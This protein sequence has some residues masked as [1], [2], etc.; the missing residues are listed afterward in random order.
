[1]ISL[2]VKYK[3]PHKIWKILYDTQNTLVVIESRDD[4]IYEPLFAAIE[5]NKNKILWENKIIKQNTLLNSLEIRHGYLFSSTFQ[6][7]QISFPKGI[8]AY[9]IFKEKIIWE[10]P[11]II[12]EKSHSKGIIAS[13]LEKENEKIF[14]EID[15]NGVENQIDSIEI[16]TFDNIQHPS[17]YYQGE[18]YFDTVQMFIFKR[19]HHQAI[20]QIDY[21][22]SNNLLFINYIHQKN[23]II[24]KEFVILSK[25]GK[26]IAQYNIDNHIKGFGSPS[27]FVSQNYLFLI[28]N[29]SELSVFNL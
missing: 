13:K 5:L 12:F 18:T 26:I 16:T 29:S 22:E 11:L 19:F 14:F 6:N 25:E 9:D 1:M 2:L 8:I 17:S 7:H 4:Q 21:L 27:F 10:N 3:S 24:S 28:Q 15:K 20:S 23:E